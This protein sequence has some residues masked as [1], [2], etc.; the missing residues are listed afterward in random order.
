MIRFFLEF[1]FVTIAVLF[2]RLITFG[3]FPS[4]EIKSRGKEF[5]FNTGIIIAAITLVLLFYLM[6]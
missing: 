3:K 6:K 2:L 1:F 5:L 4:P